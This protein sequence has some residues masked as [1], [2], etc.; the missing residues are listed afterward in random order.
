MGERFTSWR[1]RHGIKT[2]TE[3]Q[4]EAEEIGRRVAEQHR[5][6]SE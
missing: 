1:H 5:R 4:A 6:M 3:V 2:G